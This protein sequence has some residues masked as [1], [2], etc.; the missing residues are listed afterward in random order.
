NAS[1]GGLRALGENVQNQLRTVEDFQVGGFVDGAHLR[2]REFPVEDDHVW[3]ELQAV[4]ADVVELAFAAE[5]FRI[6]RREALD[7]LVEYGQAAG[8][9]QLAQ[10]ID[11]I[12]RLGHRRGGHADQDSAV[13]VV[14][15][16][17]RASIARHLFF[18]RCNQLDEI[19]VE[20][21]W[22]S[23]IEKAECLHLAIFISGGSVAFSRL[24]REQVS[25]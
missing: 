24:R 20:M 21:T 13:A 2:G 17:A 16:P 11:R 15:S 9:R 6:E 5:G 23:R 4:N 3:G 10:F 12:A 8:N 7:D 18:E 25:G 1:F 22:K 14:G 19:Y